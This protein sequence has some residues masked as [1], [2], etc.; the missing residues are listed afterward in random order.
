MTRARRGA[1][2]RELT[3]GPGKLCMA[4]GID[5]TLDGADLLGDRVWIEPGERRLPLAAIARGPRVGIDY[6]GEWAQV[7]W[8]FWVRGNAFVSGAAGRA[9]PRKRMRDGDEPAADVSAQARTGRPR[10][11]TRAPSAASR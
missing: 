5:R 11:R 9:A 8:R 6:A 7:P 10:L 2:H 3:S 1:P 4:L